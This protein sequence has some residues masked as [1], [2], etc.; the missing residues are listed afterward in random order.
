[1]D[2]ENFEADQK[3]FFL[4]L[5]EAGGKGKLLPRSLEERA[6]PADG[7]WRGEIS[8][9]STATTFVPYGG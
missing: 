8:A 2:S 5:Q 4:K 6:V 1:M 3:S 7:A 9:T